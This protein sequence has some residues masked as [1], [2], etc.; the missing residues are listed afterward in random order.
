M[1]KSFYF[2]IFIHIPHFD[3]SIINLIFKN[4]LAIFFVNTILF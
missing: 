4:K 3:Y 1:L 2:I